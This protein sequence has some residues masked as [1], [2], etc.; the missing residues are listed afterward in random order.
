M[1]KRSS[2]CR[3]WPA[4]AARTSGRPPHVAADETQPPDHLRPQRLETPAQGRLR[5]PLADPQQTPAMSVNL[6]NHG[7]E[8]IRPLA[9]PQWI[10]ST[11][12][13]GTPAV[14]GAPGPS[15]QTIPPSDRRL[16]N[17]CGRPAPSPARSAA[18]P[19]GKENTS[20]PGHRSLAIAPRHVLHHHP[21]LRAFDPP[22]GVAKPGHNSPQRHKPPTPF[23]QAVIARRRPLALGALPRIPRCGQ[24]AS[25]LDYGLS[26]RSKRTSGKQNPQKVVSGSISF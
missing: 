13:A 3:A 21:M 4:W 19:S 14:A 1:W 18:V 22:G 8:I 25:Q 24:Q 5:A 7:Q 10:S 16:P 26:W 6:V 15:A 23:R 12:I 17:W 20:W 9:L 11:P 2:T